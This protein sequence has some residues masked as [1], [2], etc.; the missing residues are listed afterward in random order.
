[1]YEEAFRCFSDID[2]LV[3]ALPVYVDGVPASVLHFLEKAEYFIKENNCNFKLYVISNC[4]FYEGRQCKHLLNIMQNFCRAAGLTWAGGIGI[5]AGEML[6]VIRVMPIFALSLLLFSIPPLLLTGASF[7]STGITVAA[8]ISVFLLLCS[9]LFFTIRKLGKAIRQ[10]KTTSEFYT[11]LA[12]CPRFVFLILAN[13][14]FIV[15][16]SLR[17]RGFWEMYNNRVHED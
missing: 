8:L 1:M 2:A 7:L 17:G 12:L 6:S 14:Y 11:G 9:R 10:G 16:A 5:G 3:I 15:R 4:G 13:L